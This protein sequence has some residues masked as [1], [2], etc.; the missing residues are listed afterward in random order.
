MQYDLWKLS[1]PIQLYVFIFYLSRWW[2]PIATGWWILVRSS[3]SWML[4]Y[5]C[6]CVLL[7]LEDDDL[8]EE[9]EIGL[10]WKAKIAIVKT[11]HRKKMMW[12]KENQNSNT[13]FNVCWRKWWNIL[14][15]RPWQMIH[16]ITGKYNPYNHEYDEYWIPWIEITS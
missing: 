2:I 10:W 3:V 8:Q 11:T 1:L 6:I 13:F 16:L 5:F 12:M 4:T 7:V 9:V 15:K 14:G